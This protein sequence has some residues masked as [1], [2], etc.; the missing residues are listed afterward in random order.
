MSAHESPCIENDAVLSSDEKEC[1][2]SQVLDKF[3]YSFEPNEEAVPSKYTR[4]CSCNTSLYLRGSKSM[5]W[6]ETIF[7][8]A[9]PRQIRGCMRT[10]FSKRQLA[11]ALW[12]LAGAVLTMATMET[13]LWDFDNS[14]LY[15]G[16]I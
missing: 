2:I 6:R 7:D 5:Q 14:P 3:D 9:V 13:S 12:F 4:T 16:S 1:L 8:F 10:N 15:Y 11:D